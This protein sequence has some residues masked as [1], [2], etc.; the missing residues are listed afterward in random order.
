MIRVSG[1]TIKLDRRFQ[2]EA[3]GIFEK[4]TFDVGVL[5]DAPHKN[6]LT[7]LQGRK[8]AWKKDIKLT[9]TEARAQGTLKSY[10]G[11]PA[12]KVSTKDSGKTIAEVSEDLRK[13]TGINFYSLPFKSKKNA[14]ILKFL[15]SFFDLCGGR[16]EVKRVENTLQAI[17]RNPILR[18]DYGKN[19]PATAKAKGFNRFM[20]DTAQLFKA[21]TAKVRRVKT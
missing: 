19:S 8:R 13:N 17:V 15:K 21:I 18:G 9:P 11:G 1:A 2:K 16:G 6:P 10:A 5:Q 14:D 12:R 4:Y 3:K 20:I 7:A